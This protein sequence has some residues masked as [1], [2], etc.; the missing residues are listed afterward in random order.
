MVTKFKIF[1]FFSLLINFSIEGKLL[2]EEGADLIK[3]D[4]WNRYLG[5][6]RYEYPKTKLITRVII[7]DFI[8]NKEIDDIRN[9]N[10]GYGFVLSTRLMTGY[11]VVN[12]PTFFIMKFDHRE[13]K[14]K[15]KQWFGDK[16]WNTTK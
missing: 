13:K 8:I 4:K 15:W 11:N 10:I 16:L 3:C 7:N 5:Y 14:Q 2:D 9:K 1:L 12:D 6:P